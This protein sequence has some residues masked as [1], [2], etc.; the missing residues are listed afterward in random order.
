MLGG[1]SESDAF[2]DSVERY[3]VELNLWNLLKIKLPQKL[4][5]MFAFT[6]K[7]DMIIIMGGLKKFSG[8][9]GGIS[10]KD[11]VLQKTADN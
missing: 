3:N 5:N 7:E 11:N 1:R 6:F 9:I 4:C 10:D 8:G 2:Y